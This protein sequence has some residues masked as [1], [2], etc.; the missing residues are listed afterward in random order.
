MYIEHISVE[1][2]FDA[3][4][5]RSHSFETVKTY[6]TSLKKFEQF[7]KEQY[8]SNSSEIIERI[9][10]GKID[11]YQL[12]RSF[13]V[14]QDK[15]G[16]MP[17]TIDI[18]INAAKE[19]LR[20]VG[21]KIYSEDFKQS[22]PLPR[23]LKV[24]ETPLTKEIILRVLRNVSPKLQAA[25]LV[26]V[27]SG[28][29]IGELVQLKISDIDF[30][31]EP[32]TIHLRAE[33]TKTRTARDVFLTKES[34]LALK[35]YLKRYHGW[36]NE[37]EEFLKNRYVF[38]RTS[39]SNKLYKQ[40]ND[41]KTNFVIATETLLQKGLLNS[42]KKIPDLCIKNSNSKY[43]IHFHAFRKFF[44]T[45]VGNASGRDFAE[46][47]IGHSFY[48]DTYYNLPEDKK[49]ELYLKAEP[50]LTISDFKKV[51]KNLQEMSERHEKLEKTV[52]DL[53]HYLFSNSI[54][55]PESIA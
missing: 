38:A 6:R 35:D 14:D 12:L 49:K 21:I 46:A 7:L 39:L 9:K 28:M 2:F 36:K 25:I 11:V 40:D 48:L 13:V 4:Y 41:L 42:I 3:K 55:I 43:A 16:F 24:V 51:E 17:R 26:A 52:E 50:Y 19:Y 22:V 8:Q 34:T 1:G 54:Q 45:N 18:R 31:A 20:Y 32:T 5:V 37:N 23:K 27:A 33:T 30:E 15:Q 53:K 47:L 29:R 10:E 44:R